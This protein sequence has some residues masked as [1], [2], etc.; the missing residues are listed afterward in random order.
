MFRIVPLCLALCLAVAPFGVSAASAKSAKPA[1]N[2]AKPKLL[3][4]DKGW[5]AYVAGPKSNLVCYL[6]GHPEKSLPAKAKR[7]RIALQVT[8]RPAEKALSV[9][10]FELGYTA[11][12][13]SSADLDIDG[14]KFKLFTNK[15]AAWNR[16]AAGDRMVTSTLALGHRAVLKAVSDHGTTTI[17]TY[18]LTGFTHALLLVD[19]AC[20]VKR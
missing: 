20:H 13:G 8:N 18:S 19:K 16:D 3:G 1:S 4:S 5:S 15:D 2:D 6:V 10:S 14:K 11:K 17:D 9:V 7:G 12:P